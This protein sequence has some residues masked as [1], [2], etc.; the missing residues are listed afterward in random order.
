MAADSI[1][2]VREVNGSLSRRGG[3]GGGGERKGLF[4]IMDYDEGAPQKGYLFS[5]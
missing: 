4:P 1:N 5:G 3:G 2:R